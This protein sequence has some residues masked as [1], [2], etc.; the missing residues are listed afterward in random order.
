M[1]R[2]T[3]PLTFD[4]TR[5]ELAGVVQGLLDAG[6]RLALVAG[7][8]DAAGAGASGDFRIVYAFLRPGGPGGLGE[9][10]EITLRIPAGGSRAWRGCRTPADGSS[11]RSATCSG[12]PSA[13]TRS[14]TD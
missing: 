8:E 9:R 10:A 4:P 14:R 13:T 11:G 1:T 12:S 3:P 7:H 5:D 2:R 6:W